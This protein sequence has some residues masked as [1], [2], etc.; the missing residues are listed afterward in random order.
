MSVQA[1]IDFCIT[2]NCG[3]FASVYF[4]ENKTPK[5]Q[6]DVHQFAEINFEILDL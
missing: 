4:R 3:S 1:I 2:V 5:N 6:H